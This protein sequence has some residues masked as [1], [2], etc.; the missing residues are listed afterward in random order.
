MSA[1]TLKRGRTIMPKQRAQRAADWQELRMTMLEAIKGLKREEALHTAQ[2]IRKRE[3]RIRR[4]LRLL[5]PLGLCPST[6]L[7]EV[8]RTARWFKAG[9]DFIRAVMALEPVAD[10]KRL[11]LN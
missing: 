7:R 10:E 11:P 6:P 2:F 9:A 1:G 4:A 8:E 3:L 5:K